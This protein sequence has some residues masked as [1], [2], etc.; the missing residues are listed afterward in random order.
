MF[1][2]LPR[3]WSCGGSRITIRTSS[4]QGDRLPWRK[5]GEPLASVL[6]L[7]RKWA[8]CLPIQRLTTL[9]TRVCW[10]YLQGSCIPLFFHRPSFQSRD[11]YQLL[12]LARRFRSPRR[13]TNQNHLSLFLPV[14][15]GHAADPWR[16]SA[17]LTLVKTTTVRSGNIGYVV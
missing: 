6:P 7:Y 14:E 16:A 10:C 2:L 12:D 8:E 1:V 17:A 11:W 3:H 5:E 15:Y 4:F 13:A 9:M